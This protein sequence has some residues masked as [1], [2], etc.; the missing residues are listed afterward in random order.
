MQ[1][2]N[3]FSILIIYIYKVSCYIDSKKPFKY[4]LK[5]WKKAESLSLKWDYSMVCNQCKVT[6]DQYVLTFKIK[7]KT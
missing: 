1:S 7:D 5:K 6:R 4:E 3:D 2:Y